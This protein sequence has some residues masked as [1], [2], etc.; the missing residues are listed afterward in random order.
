MK[1]EA[2]FFLYLTPFFLVVGGWYAWWSNGE[3]VGT[4]GLLLVGGLMGMIGFYLALLSRRIDPRPED[5]GYADVEQGAGDQGVF[6]PWSWWPLVL[7]ASAA[8]SFLAL[9]IG[10]WLFPIGAAVAVIGLTGWVM[11]FSRGQHAH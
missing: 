6:S 9:A 10:W 5:D 8:I 2:K 3:P 11:E 4:A 1:F 7:A